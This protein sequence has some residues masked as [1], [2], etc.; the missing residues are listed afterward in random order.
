MGIVLSR[1]AYAKVN[2]HLAVGAPYADG[3]HPIESIFSLVDLADNI[4][5]TWSAS[6]AFSISVTGLESY[7]DKGSDTLTKA[8]LLWHARTLLPLT[9][10]VHC[11]KH[12]PVKAGLGGGSSDAAS[13]LLL[14]QQ[15]AGASALAP[16]QLRQVALQVGSDVPFFLSGLPCALVEGRGEKL[17]ALPLGPKHIVLA[18]PRDYS[19]STREAYARIDAL[20]ERNELQERVPLQ[21]V[22]DTLKKGT[23]RWK[24]VF[25]NDFEKCTEYPEFY[26]TTK[27]LGDAYDGFGSLSGSGSCWFFI[28]E[29][30]K[31]VLELCEK[32]HERFMDSVQLWCTKLI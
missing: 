3:Y 9:V 11:E 22:L 18:Q 23:S 16:E 24:G 13:L 12:I 20:L 15:A 7:C 8:A 17:R 6:D 32:L 26:E 2:L 28:S 25:F 4:E 30:D 31:S 29:N 1:H 10:Q 27:I 19:V 5:M 21:A 14:L